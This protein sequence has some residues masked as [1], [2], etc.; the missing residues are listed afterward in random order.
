MLLRGFRYLCFGL[1]RLL[2][3]YRL[4]RFRVGM[5]GESEDMPVLVLSLVVFLFFLMPV[6][7]LMSHF[8]ST[9]FFNSVCKGSIISENFGMNLLYHDV[10][11]IILCSC[12]T[13]FG[14]GNSNIGFIL[15]SSINSPFS[16]TTNP[17]YFTSE[18]PN[19]HFSR[20]IVNLAWLIFSRTVSNV[21]KCSSKFYATIIISSR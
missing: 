9:P 21:F 3:L 13:F 16:F 1:R 10:I 12:F 2:I 8:H 20:F 11:S 7:V 15:S 17:K 14:V 6:L 18:H 4:H 19:S 5:D